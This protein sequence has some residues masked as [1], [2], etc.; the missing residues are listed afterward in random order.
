MQSCRQVPLPLASASSLGDDDVSQARQREQHRE[1]RIQEHGRADAARRE[2]VVEADHDALHSRGK[3][4][5][6]GYG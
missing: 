5:F 2:E 1:E 4:T 3:S 6:M